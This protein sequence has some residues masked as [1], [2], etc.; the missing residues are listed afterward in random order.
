MRNVDLEKTVTNAISLYQTGRDRVSTIFNRIF[1]FRIITRYVLKEFLPTFFISFLFFFVIFF[2]NHILLIIKPLLEKNI[3][4]DLIGTMMLTAFPMIIVLSL[5]FGTMLSTLMTMGRF[6]TDNEIIAFRALGFSMMKIFGPLIICGFGFFVTAFVV[7]DYFLPRAWHKQRQT[8]RKIMSI[9]PTLDFKSKTVKQ[10][11]GK[12]IFT[13]LV[14]DTSIEGLIIIDQDKRG[15]KRIISAKNAEIT[16]PEERKGVIELKM[17]SAMMQTENH[18]RPNEFNYGYADIISYYIVFQEFDEQGGDVTPAQARTFL[19]ILE[20]VRR[21]SKARK[22]DLESRERQSAQKKTEI[23]GYRS[24]A[25]DLLHGFINF[26][27]YQSDLGRID[28]TVSDI[29]NR[30]QKKNKF[31]SLNYNKIEMYK[32]FAFPLACIIFVIFAAPIGIYSKRAGFSIGFVVGLF[33]TAFY[34]F[35]FMGCDIL[36]KKFVLSPFFAMLLPN[37]IFLVVGIVFLIKRLRE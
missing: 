17:N 3:P 1:K 33:L 21:Y 18:D 28:S 29:M 6:S 5:P 23:F 35:S 8:L 14:K 26:S 19:E 32:K 31:V 4:L 27:Q 34:W 13:N 20:D 10:H 22:R 7:N 30:Q 25:E 16:S 36:G 24:R 37:L 9:K 11:F 12:T 15:Q 2:I